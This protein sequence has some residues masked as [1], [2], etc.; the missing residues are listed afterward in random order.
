MLHYPLQIFNESPILLSFFPSGDGDSKT[1][2]IEIDNPQILLSSLKKSDNGY[3]AVLYNASENDNITNV[4][5]NPA[6]E[7]FDLKFGKHEIKTLKFNI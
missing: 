7:K 4:L 3:E 2:V 1:S 6:K 5:I